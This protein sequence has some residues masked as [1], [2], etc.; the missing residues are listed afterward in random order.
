VPGDRSSLAKRLSGLS[1]WG[2]EV[3]KAEVTVPADRVRTLYSKPFE[4]VPAKVGYTLIPV[5]WLVEHDE[6]KP[7]TRA[8]GFALV[9]FP[10]APPVFS[11]E[12]GQDSLQGH[13]FQH[14][15]FGPQPQ[16]PAYGY[17]ARPLLLSALEA[18]PEDGDYDLSAEVWYVELASPRINM[19]HNPT[20]TWDANGWRLGLGVGAPDW[21][22]EEGGPR[23]GN[24]GGNAPLEPETPLL[25]L[26]GHNY[27]VTYTAKTADNFGLYP[28]NTFMGKIASVFLVDVT[29]EPKGGF[30]S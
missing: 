14:L 16:M 30:R 3:R 11:V 17:V 8:T 6:G 15:V 19:L 4:I 13:A 23:H 10:G 20:F 25:I 27:R 21:A 7:Y 28:T 9:H 29:A 1:P 22:Y 12:E 2:L 5:Q 26:P 24:A 18:D